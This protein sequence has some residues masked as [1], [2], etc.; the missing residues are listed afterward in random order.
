MHASLQSGDGAPVQRKGMTAS[1]TVDVAK[2]VGTV[3]VSVNA[4]CEADVDEKA[5]LKLVAKASGAN[6]SNRGESANPAFANTP[7]AKVLATRRRLQLLFLIFY[8]VFII[9]L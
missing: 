2:M 9:I 5:I 7:S 4:R 3:H 6:Y 8:Y 1:H